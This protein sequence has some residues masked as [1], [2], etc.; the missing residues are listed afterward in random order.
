MRE[1]LP[2]CSSG[3]EASSLLRRDLA[4]NRNGAFMIEVVCIQQ[5]ENR[6]R[7]PKNASPDVHTSRTACLSRAPGDWPPL[8]PAPIRRNMGWFSVNG[9]ISLTVFARTGVRGVVRRT[10]RRPPRLTLGSSPRPSRRQSVERETPNA[11]TA[12]SIVNRF[13]SIALIVSPES[14]C[15]TCGHAHEAA[16][17]AWDRSGSDR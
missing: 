16:T 9:W 10:R 1:L 14:H 3:D 8:R 12:S 2:Q 5:R 17:C 6:A 11:W 13:P 4:G 7:I 15:V